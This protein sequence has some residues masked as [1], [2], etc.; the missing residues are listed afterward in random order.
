MQR[1]TTLELA[2]LQWEPKGL[3]TEFRQVGIL[4]LARVLAPAY[5]PGTRVPEPT[6]FKL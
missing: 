6:T 3:A 5:V 1:I 2:H 4:V